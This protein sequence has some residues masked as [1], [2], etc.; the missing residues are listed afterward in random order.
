MQQNQEPR[1]Q[2]SEIELKNLVKATLKTGVD[3][4]INEGIGHLKMALGNTVE[5]YV[6]SMWPELTT[7]L[8]GVFEQFNKQKSEKDKLNALKKDIANLEK[9]DGQKEQEQKSEPVP[10]SPLD[11]TAGQSPAN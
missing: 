10:E 7:Q 5:K 3:Q 11:P 1:K 9:K 8:Y 4:I 2:L 6:D